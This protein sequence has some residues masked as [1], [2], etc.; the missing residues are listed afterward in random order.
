MTFQKKKG[1]KWENLN[2]TE[3]R[4]VLEHYLSIADKSK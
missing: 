4:L 2:N 3:K 1:F